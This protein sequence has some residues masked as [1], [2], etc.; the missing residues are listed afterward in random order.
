[1]QYLQGVN[2]R[3]LA[4][5]RSYNVSSIVD[6]SAFIMMMR[7]KLHKNRNAVM[8]LHA[9][10]IGFLFALFLITPLLA[11]NHPHGRDQQP[12]LGHDS[13]K[14]VAIIGK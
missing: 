11:E 4:F 13:T 6:Q 12:L 14:R 8:M 3:Q 5:E 9:P 2:S 1:V 7:E 10:L